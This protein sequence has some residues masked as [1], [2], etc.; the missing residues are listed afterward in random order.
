MRGNS[1][2]ATTGIGTSTDTMACKLLPAEDSHSCSRGG[3]LPTMHPEQSLSLQRSH[4]IAGYDFARA[5]AVTGMVFV[6]FRYMLESG[7]NGPDWLIWLS[8]FI[9]GR[10]SATFVVLAGVGITLLT[11][12]TPINKGLA[13]E[14]HDKAE[15]FKRALFLFVLGLLV[16]RIWDADILHFFSVYFFLS[17]LVVNAANR[18]LGVLSLLVFV[19]FC[20]QLG[21]YH[22][23]SSR[24]LLGLGEI[25][26]W[27]RMGLIIDILFNGFYPVFPWM[28]F[29]FIG[30]WLGRLNVSDVPLQKKLLFGSCLGLALSECSAVLIARLVPSDHGMISRIAN[31]FE[32]VPWPPTLLYL[33]SGGGSAVLII[34]LSM[35][36]TGKMAYR[37]WMWPVLATGRLSLTHYVAHLVISYMVLYA[38]NHMDRE[39]TLLCSSISAAIYC[40][41]ALIFSAYWL[42]HH[43][44]GPLESLMR[45]ISK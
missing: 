45:W 43:T 33:I 7:E 39:H 24:A 34:S 13:I 25:H 35:A 27:I 20:F 11:H 38:A 26:S 12:R 16:Y 30:M 37:K 41:S 18:T 9:E 4:R 32:I 19:V 2:Q 42:K 29:V 28:I 8:D 5:L 15:L 36:I 10:P 1:R 44:R 3:T 14:E 17:I 6:N 22:F 31:V 23:Y 40:M 21:D